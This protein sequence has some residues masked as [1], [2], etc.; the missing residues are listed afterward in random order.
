MPVCIAGMHRSGTSMVARLLHLCGL[1][2]GQE[3]D[4]KHGSA[5]NPEG[6]WENV[7]LLKVNEDIL[8][9]LGSAWDCPPPALGGWTEEGLLRLRAKAGVVLQEFHGREPWGWKDPRN[10]LTFPFWADLQPD[11]KVVICLRNPL[12]VTLSLNRR[13]LSSYILGLKLWRVYNE[14]I[15]EATTRE[16]RI[17]THYDAFFN[18][19]QAELRRILSFLGMTAS[20][21]LIQ[22]VC[23]AAQDDL[24]HHRFTTQHLV[25]A[26]ASMD[27][28]KLYLELCAEAGWMEESGE[29]WTPV[30][31]PAA[32]TVRP[33]SAGDNGSAP[34]GPARATESAA[35][36][37]ARQR[38]LPSVSV[39]EVGRLNRWVVDLE[40]ARAHR[41]QLEKQIGQPV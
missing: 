23:P 26:N 4:L 16:Q 6:F 40:R 14:R 36:D 13:N 17:V 10:S 11:M 37:V 32:S 30:E 27:M 9:E 31:A 18:D 25:D 28:L 3:D 29:R 19:P 8:G 35:L 15:L 38:Q 21:E 34:H 7:K 2:L 1:Y 22:E 5:N 39:I 24:R 20:D 41:V 33:G 12:E